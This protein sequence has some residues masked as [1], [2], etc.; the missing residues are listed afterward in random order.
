[1]SCERS[2]RMAGQTIEL[3]SMAD[4]DFGSESGPGKINTLNAIWTDDEESL[5]MED[6][7]SERAVLGQVI[8]GKGRIVKMVSVRI[9]GSPVG[10][11]RNGSGKSEEGR[12]RGFDHV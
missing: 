8:E 7:E 3:S 6:G 9:E 4:L 10:G 1:M 2:R 5:K 11:A 12:M